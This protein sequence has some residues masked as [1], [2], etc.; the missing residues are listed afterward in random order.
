MPEPVIAIFD[1]GK[2]NK[3]FFLFDQRYRI[4]FEKTVHLEE[5]VD[6]D[7]FPCED[8]GALQQFVKDG[9]REAQNISDYTI[10]AVNNSSYGASLAFLDAEGNTL[11]CVYNYLKPY[12]DY[13]QKE[14]F[15]KHGGRHVLSFQTASPALGSLNTGLQLYRIKQE[16]PGLFEQIR[17][18]LHLP[19]YIAYLLCGKP[20]AEMTSLGCHTM[21]WDFRSMNYHPWVVREKIIDRFP[22]IAPADLVV[23]SP[24]SDDHHVV[25][26]GV[27]D[28]SAALIPYLVKY[29]EPFALVSTGTWAITLNPSNTSALTRQELECDCLSYLQYKG[30]PV[31][32]SR[33]FAGHHHDLQVK[34]I[35][36]HFHSH[37][38]RYAEMP[39]DARTLSRIDFAFDITAEPQQLLRQLRFE[40]RE[41]S[42]FPDDT[43][44]YHQLMYDL[45]VQQFVSTQLVVRGTGVRKLFVDGGFSRNEIYMNLLAKFFPEMEVY[46]SDV[47]QAS[48]IGAALAIHDTWN[49][50][51][52][53]DSL[54]QLKRYTAHS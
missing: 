42:G 4:V 38:G 20:F 11:G 2:T 51:S 50:A 27:H 48:A 5:T 49:S 44:A 10:K 33:L 47:P 25:G 46:A 13:L 39:F 1:I 19:Q 23:D 14:F 32:A 45:V 28:S 7:G 53:P 43:L 26:I 36:E 6:P 17:Y 54:L 35:A 34:R 18:A 8:L 52:L 24:A 40:T 21:L 29:D 31:K 15:E 12:P 3:K 30:T 9:L 16:Q 22:E 37:V 41:L